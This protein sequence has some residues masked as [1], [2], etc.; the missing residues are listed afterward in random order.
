MMEIYSHARNYMAEHGNPN[1]WGPANWPP[2]D[3]IRND[4][5]DGNSYVCLNDEGTVIGT[6]CITWAFEQTNISRKNV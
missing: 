5:R 1:Q 6:F 2:K 4:I 3:L